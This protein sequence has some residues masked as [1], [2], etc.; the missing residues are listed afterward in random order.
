M[1]ALFGIASSVGGV[2]SSILGHSKRKRARRQAEA[3]ARASNEEATKQLNKEALRQ[4]S[5]RR[6]SSLLN[7][8]SLS[9]GTNML[10]DNSILTGDSN[11]SSALSGVL[12]VVSGRKR[13]K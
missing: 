7:P 9:S 12:A 1:N 5:R 3:L 13:S 8:S 2:V 4:A 11:P 6:A 10:S